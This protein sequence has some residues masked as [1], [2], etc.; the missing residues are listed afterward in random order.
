MTAPNPPAVELR[1]LTKQ[2]GR[3]LANGG[4]NL[5]VEAGT[6]HGVIGENGAGKST[7]M[8]ILY[9]MLRPDA[10][11]IFVG[12]TKRVWTSPSDAIAQGIGMVHQ[13]FMLAGPYSALD[14]IRTRDEGAGVLGECR[15]QKEECRNGN[16]SRSACGFHSAFGILHS[17][18]GRGRGEVWPSKNP[19]PHIRNMK[20][21]SHKHLGLPDKSGVPY[22]LAAV[23]ALG[24]LNL[25]ASASTLAAGTLSIRNDTLIA[26]YNDVSN[27]FQLTE[28]TWGRAFLKEGRLEGA[29]GKAQVESVRD[30]VF[31]SGKRIVL[32]RAG[33]GAISIELYKD[34][35]FLLVRGELRNEG[36][37]VAE[38]TSLSP[39]SFEL[40]MGRAGTELRTMGTAGLTPPDKNPGSYLFLTLADPATRRG[41]VAGWLTA[42]RGSGVI[43]SDVPNDRVRFRA[44]TDY[45]HL[46]LEPGETAKLETLAIG[47]FDDARIGQELYAEAM[48]RHYSIHLPTPPAGYCTWYSQ[49]HG[50]AADEKSIITLGE[51]AAKELKPFGFSFIQIDDQWQDGKERNGPARRFMRAKPNG[52]YPNGM[53]P[54]AERLHELGLTAGLWFLPFASDY[55]DPEFKDRQ[56]WF[57][58]RSDGKPYE[59]PWGNTSLD[60]TRPDVQAYLAEMARTIHG[61][62]YNYFKMDGLWTGTATEQIYVNDGYRDDHIGN[63][64]PFHNPK[65]T[66]LEAFRDGLRLL[67]QA[68]GPEVFFSGCNVSQNMRTLGGT[69]GLL[70]SMRIGPDNGHGW[71]NYRREIEKNAGGS[72]ITGPIRGTRLYFLNGRTWWNDPD[73]SYVR[74]SIPIKHAR[75]IT[76][77]VA[78]SGQVYLNSD[79][80]PG[81]PAERLDIIKRT[82]PTHNATAR[83]IDYFETIM[84]RMWL[85]TDTRQAVRR[86][87]LGLYNW[88]S[89]EQAMN[90]PAAKAGLAPAKTYFAFDFWS[91]APAPSFVGE[92]NYKVPAQSCRVIA[93]RAAAG[94]PVLVSTSRHV[95]QGMVDVLGEKWSGLTKTL[96]G[97]SQLVGGDSY[98]LRVAGLN[99]HDKLWKLVSAS[100]SAADKAA[101]VSIEVRPATASEDGWARIVINSKDSRPVNWSLKFAT[102]RR[103]SPPRP[104]TKSAIRAPI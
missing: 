46:R 13:H 88:E 102:E 56:E 75:L 87:V 23:L 42:D 98:E 96:S 34:L 25:L 12:G 47:C 48:A 94:H 70:D 40:D 37:A 10:G 76:S 51:C 50:G 14:N 18:S 26:S 86:D 39:A 36:P 77:W 89:E 74:A 93:V 72:L 83:P 9:G 7:A 97:T 80:L 38:V 73:P 100:V 64:A 63:N 20:T 101:G 2:F 71:G 31:K 11:E 60:L 41:V 17:P 66:N 6:I 21:L 58:R 30:P 79:W 55:Q 65:K 54:T 3:V 15:R 82:I 44:Q 85:V 32:K 91:N 84:P 43:F 49:P 22:C 8:K 69:I 29:T 16:G 62:G 95:T 28:R 92:F 52:P 27:T 81:L 99:H 68:A 33:G 104:V 4:V 78:L 5:R 35:P 53:R 45:G 90:C 1:G 59:T 19:N 61:W 67:R 57:A 24:I 103:P